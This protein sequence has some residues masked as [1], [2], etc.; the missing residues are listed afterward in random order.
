MNK[1]Y[2]YTIFASVFI[3]TSCSNLKPFVD[4][5]RIIGAETKEDLYTGE[6]KNEFPVICYNGLTTTP[7][8]VQ[9]LADKECIK[10]G[11][12]TKAKFLKREKF[13]C[14]LF[15]PHYLIYQCIK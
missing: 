11:T 5:R 13:K 3:L 4:R 10:N 2:F 7:K 6:S 1:K 14:R 8:E 9:K 15:L 12:G